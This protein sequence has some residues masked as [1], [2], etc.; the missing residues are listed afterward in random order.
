MR[1]PLRRLLALS[2]AS[3]DYFE[4]DMDSIQDFNRR[5]LARVCHFFTIFLLAGWIVAYFVIN[6]AL[7]IYFY[8]V[9]LIIQLLLNNVV[10]RLDPNKAD[11]PLRIQRLCLIQTFLIMAFIIPVSIFPFPD[12]PAVLFAPVLIAISILFYMPLWLLFLNVCCSS[13]I[14]LLLSAIFKPEQAFLHDLLVSIFAF[15]I[16]LIC[17]YT[18]TELR[19]R[20]FSSRWRWMLLSHLDQHT[21][22]FN[23]ATAEHLFKDRLAQAVPGERC[24]FLLLDL[25][26]FKKVNDS[27][28]HAQGDIVIKET[29]E[30]IRSCL[31]A[32]DIAGRFG[33][34]EFMLLLTDVP[35]AK[36]VRQ[37]A[38][39]L[40][41]EVT[42]RCI[43]RFPQHTITCCVGIAFGS[44]CCSYEAFF[45]Q[46][47]SALYAAKGRGN[48]QVMLT[49]TPSSDPELYPIFP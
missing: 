6:I 37:R 11:T 47:D 30:A 41:H 36:E 44:A 39:N 42:N 12:F 46:A 38:L 49:N 3:K 26:E 24:A 18:L 15:F 2:R 28:G 22:L 32:N 21:H 1:N 45:T 29:A 14:F 19:V 48:G 7:L 25:D 34:D 35:H 17:I 10:R 33:G 23:K 43:A 9:F 4:R 5:A 20:D 13:V 40:A 27:L 31:G 8:V 16:A